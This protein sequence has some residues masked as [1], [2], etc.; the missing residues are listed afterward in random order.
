MPN[1]RRKI[2]E[3]TP[4]KI[5]YAFI[6]GLLVQNF[7]TPMAQAESSGIT[8][9]YKMQ[10]EQAEDGD[11][12][13]FSEQAGQLARCIKPYDERV[14]GIYVKKPDA[15]LRGGIDQKPIAREGKTIVNVTTLS[16]PIEPGDYLTTSQVAG[17]GQKAAEPLGYV[18][19]RSLGSLKEGEGTKFEINGREAFLGKIEVALDFA[20]LGVLPRGTILDKIGFAF[21]KGTQ[22]PQAAGLFLRYIVAGVLTT[23]VVIVSFNTFGKNIGKGIEAIGRNPLAKSYIQ[24]VIII[25]TLLI[26]ALTFGAIF[27]GLVIIRV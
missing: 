23:V 8:S 16:G 11:I 15:V 6:L 20:A 7:F 21:V 10:D 22:T 12:V 17:K 9:S 24:F 25:N 18:I 4:N 2:L 5:L 13:C 19:G 14:F 27:L 26:A 3:L 1:R